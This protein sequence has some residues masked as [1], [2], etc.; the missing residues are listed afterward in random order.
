MSSVRQATRICAHTRLLLIQ[1]FRFPR[2]KQVNMP[3]AKEASETA[4]K[5]CCPTNQ[6]S[7]L[8]SPRWSS[9]RLFS[10]FV[11]LILWLCL[12]LS[13]S[14]SMSDKGALMKGTW[15][16]LTVLSLSCSH[17]TLSESPAI[18]TVCLYWNLE[19]HQSS[20][21]ESCWCLWRQ[22][23]YLI[24]FSIP[25]QFRSLVSCHNSPTCQ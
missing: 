5:R 17:M 18:V 4:L 2:G 10:D 21:N 24:G 3:A 1:Q 11:S 9:H 19:H 23:L 20:V 22:P 14:P 25:S 15:S 6:H 7:S 8:H 12:S 16:L 13:I